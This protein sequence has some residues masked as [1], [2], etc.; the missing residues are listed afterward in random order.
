MTKLLSRLLYYLG[1]VLGLVVSTGISHYLDWG[2]PLKLKDGSFALVAHKTIVLREITK[3]QF[4]FYRVLHSLVP[5]VAISGLLLGVIGWRLRKREA[6]PG[7]GEVSR[8][9]PN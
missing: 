8:D 3:E 6:Q 7:R 4:E 2:E 9:D 5:V 1:P